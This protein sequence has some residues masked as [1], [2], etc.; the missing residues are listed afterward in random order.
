MKTATFTIA[1]WDAL[2]GDLAELVKA[3]L[4]F[5]VLLT[6]LVG[7]LMGWQG[8][9]SYLILAATLVGTALCACGAAALNQWWERDSRCAHEAHPAASSPCETH[10]SK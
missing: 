1:R 3:R 9:M 5:L 2:V 4:S 6:T 10:A 8:P 7:F